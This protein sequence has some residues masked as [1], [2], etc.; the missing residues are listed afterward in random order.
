MVKPWGKKWVWDSGVGASVGCVKKKTNTI[1]PVKRDSETA[2]SWSFTP[3]F[4]PW[5][6]W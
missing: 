6:P 4:A 2:N 3:N 5:V 1:K